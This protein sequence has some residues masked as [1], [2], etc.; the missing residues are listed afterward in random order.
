[1]EKTGIR[2]PAGVLELVHDEADLSWEDLARA[3][4]TT[5]ASVYRWRRKGLSLDALVVLLK[6]ATERQLQR[7]E[8]KLAHHLKEACG[9]NVQIVLVRRRQRNGR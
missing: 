2:I 5:Q 1:M 3:I 6:F 9:P 4:D 7:S 8:S